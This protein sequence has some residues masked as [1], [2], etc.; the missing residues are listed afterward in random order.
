[1]TKVTVFVESKHRDNKTNITQFNYKAIKIEGHTRKD[2]CAAVSA[3]GWTLAGTLVNVTDCTNLVEDD[4][5]MLVEITEQ[6]TVKTNLIFETIMVGIEQI[7]NKHPDLI[8]PVS[9]MI[10][11]KE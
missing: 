6:S 8:H 3:L 1:M 2:V 4:G 11:D 7:V 5:Y 10:Q 9:I